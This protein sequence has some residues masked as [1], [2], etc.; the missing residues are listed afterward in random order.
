MCQC[1]LLCANLYELI[2]EKIH[3]SPQISKKMMMKTDLIQSQK[4][5]NYSPENRFT[6]QMVLYSGPK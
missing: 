4:K 2:T 5:K 3:S 6:K 1:Y